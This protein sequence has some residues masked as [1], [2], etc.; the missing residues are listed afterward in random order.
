M[1]HLST[2]TALAI[3]SFGGAY[4]EK[5]K[6]Q[7]KVNAT[8]SIIPSPDVAVPPLIK[9]TKQDSKVSR[10]NYIMKHG[11]PSFDSI[12]TF[13]NFVLSYDRRLRASNWVFEHLNADNLKRNADINR[14]ECD[15]FEDKSIHP[16]FR[17]K[18][19]DYRGSGYD[20][21]HLAAAGNHRISQEHCQQTFVLSNISPQGIS[22]NN[23]LYK[24]LPSY[25]HFSFYSVGRGFNRGI[26]NKLEQYVRYR[27]RRANNLWSCTGPLY[28]PK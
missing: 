1:K 28:L 5:H 21:G 13:D 23:I 25:P 22:F 11:Y 9:P 8:T 14:K 20:R 24:S 19:D 4:F 18:K 2:I 3:G 12:R 16:Y 26:W 15:F 7:F 6:D 27:A 17:A 10:V